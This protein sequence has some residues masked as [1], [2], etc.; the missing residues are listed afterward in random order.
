MMKYEAAVLA[1]NK[2][3]VID[4]VEAK[5]LFDASSSTDLVKLMKQRC[6]FEAKRMYLPTHM[7]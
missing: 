2:L 4:E 7:I 1:Y 6:Y 5:K 3:V